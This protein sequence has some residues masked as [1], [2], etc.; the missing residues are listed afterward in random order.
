MYTRALK[1]NPKHPAVLLNAAFFEE[2]QLRRPWMALQVSPRAP[3]LRA[4]APGPRTTTR[5][6]PA[7]GFREDPHRACHPCRFSFE[8]TLHWRTSDAHPAP[9][10]TRSRGLRR[11]PA[12][13]PARAPRPAPRRCDRLL[14][15]ALARLRRRHAGPRDQA[16]CPRPAPPLERG[17]ALCAWFC[18]RSVRAAPPRAPALLRGAERPARALSVGRGGRQGV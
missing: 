4:G 17:A 5:P 3:S 9:A 7:G 11:R 1:T 16:P 8:R 10:L 6:A 14:A 12:D 15:R 18:K 13:A 2:V